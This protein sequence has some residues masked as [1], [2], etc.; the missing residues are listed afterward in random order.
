MDAPE[1]SPKSNMGISKLILILGMW[2]GVEGV[3]GGE[4]GE[5]VEGEWAGGRVGGEMVV[6]VGEG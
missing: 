4:G 5:G 1:G 2:L 3:E 6:V